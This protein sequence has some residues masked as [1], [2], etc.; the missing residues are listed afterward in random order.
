MG[1]L[2]DTLGVE[3]GSRQR[4]NRGPDPVPKKNPNKMNPLPKSVLPALVV[5]DQRQ[6]PPGAAQRRRNNKARLR[7][8]ERKM[9]ELAAQENAPSWGGWGGDFE[10]MWRAAAAEMVPPR[11]SEE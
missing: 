2:V 9:H 8:E 11:R 7:E 1:A 10:T 3:S 5:A 4:R 6:R